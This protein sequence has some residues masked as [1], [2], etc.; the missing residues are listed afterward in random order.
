MEI[1]KYLLFIRCGGPPSH[2]VPTE[3][4]GRQDFMDMIARPSINQDI[5]NRKTM[6][7]TRWS[8]CLCPFLQTESGKREK[9]RRRE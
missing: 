5:K 9:E 8:K 1:R 3:K 4:A 6:R 2:S 7:G